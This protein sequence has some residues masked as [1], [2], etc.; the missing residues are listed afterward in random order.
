MQVVFQN[1]QL[2]TFLFIYHQGDVVLYLLVY[3]DDIIL[4]GSQRELVHE[5]VKIL[6][7]SFP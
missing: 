1:S 4:T 2:D 6:S 7:T 3:V 5:F